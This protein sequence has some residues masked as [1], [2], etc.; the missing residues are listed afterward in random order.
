MFCEIRVIWSR[1]KAEV[2]ETADESLAASDFFR[3]VPVGAM[4]WCFDAPAAG[5]FR[6]TYELEFEGEGLVG[7]ARLDLRARERGPGDGEFAGQHEIDVPRGR[8]SVKGKIVRDFGGVA[9]ECLE[10]P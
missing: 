2:D 7:H 10:W 6:A 5:G 8:V 9:L 1:V 3:G 4:S